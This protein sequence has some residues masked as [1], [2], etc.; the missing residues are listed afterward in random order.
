MIF[1]PDR[2]DASA[3]DLDRL[4]AHPETSDRE[5][6]RIADDLYWIPLT[7]PCRSGVDRVLAMSERI[8]RLDPSLAPGELMAFASELRRGSTAMVS[9]G[10]MATLYGGGSCK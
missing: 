3:N 8:R 4:A 7:H 1:A 10:W 9:V 6:V 2:A 5:R